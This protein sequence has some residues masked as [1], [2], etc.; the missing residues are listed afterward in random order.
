MSCCICLVDD[1]A[2]CAIHFM[3]SVPSVVYAV[4]Y[5]A[6]NGSNASGTNTEGNYNNNAYILHESVRIKCTVGLERRTSFV[7]EIEMPVNLLFHI[8]VN[9]NKKEKEKKYFVIQERPNS[10]HSDTHIHTFN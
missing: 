8:I 4:V 7:R 10:E 9:R 1:I 3:T 2:F 5:P 6:E